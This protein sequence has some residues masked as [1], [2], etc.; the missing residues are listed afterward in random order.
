[1][2]SVPVRYSRFS[3]CCHLIIDLCFHLGWKLGQA[4]DAVAGTRRLGFCSSFLLLPF[5]SKNDF[6]LCG[7]RHRSLIAVAQR[8]AGC[9]AYPQAM[10]QDRQRPPTFSQLQLPR[11]SS[12]S[13]RHLRPV[14]DPSVADRCPLQTD[15]ESGALPATSSV[16]RY[17]SPSC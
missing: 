8:F 15:R 11:V 12:H 10:Q 2:R 6:D 5:L 16:R 17:G 9:S 7:G 3:R 4:I 1:M 14:S 13:F